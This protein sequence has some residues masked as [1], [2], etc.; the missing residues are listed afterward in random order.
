LDKALGW[1]ARH[2]RLLVLLFW[3]LAAAWFTYLRWNG[4]LLFALGDTDDNMRMSQVRAWLGG[5]DW[6][7]L[8]QYKLDP[9]AGANIHWSRLVDLPLAGLITVAKL[10][11]NGGNAERFAV[12]AAPL[13]P[14]LLLGG[15]LALVARRLIHP[16]AFVLSLMTLYFAM[17]TNGMFMPTRI[18]HHG[19]QLTF[20]AIA[21]AG[22]ADPRPARGGATT[23]IATALSLSV[24]LE[25]LIYL[26]LAGAA[27]VL[28]WIDEREQR[29]RLGAYAA[30]LAGGT[31]LGFLLFAS[32]ANRAAV[33]DALS[34]VWLSDALLG[35]ALLALLAWWSPGSWK[36]RLLGAGAAG[37]AV[38]LFHALAWPHCLSRLEGV[39]PE[40]QELWLN[41]VREAKPIYG[42]PPKTV[43]VVVTLPLIGLAG[44]ILLVF[45]SLGERDRLRRVLSVAAIAVTA[46]LLLLWQTRAGPAAQMLGVTGC[47]ALAWLLVPRVWA[48][49][50]RTLS[51]LATAAVVVV[52]VG[53]AVPT[54]VTRFPD[55]PQTA[56]DKAVATANRLCP[57]IP[58]LRPVALQPKG[59]VFTFVDLAPRLITVTHHNSITG[60]YHR[61]GEA[62][63]DVMRAFRGSE[64]QAHAIIRKR[65]A[66]YV[67]TCPNMSQATLFQAQAPT[68]FYMQLEQGQVPPWLRRV[69]LPRDSPLKL[70]RVVG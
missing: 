48:L 32:Y 41:N 61:N 68:G 14:Y 15:A 50:N 35:G 31:G 8:R 45:S 43:A 13:I 60:P 4:I 52:A 19:W 37:V 54:V 22:L 2:W 3:L 69:P 49:K 17:S 9:P 10:F 47:A 7:D 20:L 65:R 67:L 64:S 1:A 21:M 59:T 70:W 38:A 26:A 44:W 58:G 53:A 30:T 55:K 36:A 42:H 12:A 46:L 51:V 25:M 33:C 27:Q 6:Y 18:D 57:S 16:A 62:I 28:M 11:T 39:S 56:R 23:G 29:Q 63:A 34:P 40:V 5:Q 66:D 24:G